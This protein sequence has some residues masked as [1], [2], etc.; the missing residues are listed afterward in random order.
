MTDNIDIAI[1]SYEFHGY[2]SSTSI[3]ERLRWPKDGLC[4]P[5][6]GEVSRT[7]YAPEQGLPS[8]KLMTKLSKAVTNM[9]L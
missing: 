5:S 4:V 6:S 7:T 2:A 3:S 8:T 1:Q 9:G